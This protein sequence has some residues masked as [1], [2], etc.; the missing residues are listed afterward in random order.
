MEAAAL[1]RL[2]NCTPISSAN[3]ATVLTRRSPHTLPARL[4]AAGR[5]GGGSHAVCWCGIMPPQASPAEPCALRQRRRQ[6]VSSQRRHATAAAAAP[7]R[8]LVHTP[9]QQ[10]SGSQGQ[11]QADA[12]DGNV[13]HYQCVLAGEGLGRASRRKRGRAISA[14]RPA[15]QPA[16]AGRACIA[17]RPCLVVV[18]EPLHALPNQQARGGQEQRAEEVQQRLRGVRGGPV[19]ALGSD[20]ERRLSRS[21]SNKQPPL[22]LLCP[23][24]INS[25]LS[26]TCCT[27]SRH[28]EPGSPAAGSPPPSAVVAAAGPCEA[29]PLPALCKFMA[30]YRNI[31]AGALGSAGV[32]PRDLQE[33][34]V[35]AG[36]RWR[37]IVAVNECWGD[38]RN[39]GINWFTLGAHGNTWA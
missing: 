28:C 14:S 18:C 38:A 25:M 36:H 27:E 17:R 23:S 16:L 31:I 7:Q 10:A 30:D 34:F 11:R 4:T 39:S 6:H 8:T 13:R 35:R 33:P 19:P 9:G 20:T 1:A 24:D 21:P 32:V 15:T 29:G 2:M 3:S 37:E 22:T 26:T 5:H 12:C